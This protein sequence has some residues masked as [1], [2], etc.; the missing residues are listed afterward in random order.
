MAHDHPPYMPLPADQAK[1]GALNYLDQMLV[2]KSMFPKVMRALLPD[3]WDLGV[4]LNGADHQW[5]K[6]P[7]KE[8]VG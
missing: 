6:D 2:R 3:K 7:L 8:V 4:R 5:G 1:R